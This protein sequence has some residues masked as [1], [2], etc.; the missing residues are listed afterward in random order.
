MTK[1]T[2]KENYMVLMTIM[3]GAK[4][5]MLCGEPS[6]LATSMHIVNL[7][8]SMFDVKNIKQPIKISNSKL[9]YASKF[10]KLQ[11]LYGAEGKEQAC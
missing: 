1:G 11:V 7:D 2:E 5:K 3:E 9:M 10:G 6:N 4:P 8:K